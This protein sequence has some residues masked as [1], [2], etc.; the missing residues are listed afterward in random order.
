MKG[1]QG[2]STR[3]LGI[4]LIGLGIISQRHELGFQ[5]A[6]AKAKV[7]AL[8]D[9]N[10][11][12]A[13][14]RA[15]PYKANAYSD[16]HELIAD[17]NIDIVDIALPHNL[18]FPVAKAAIQAGKHVLVEKPLALTSAEAEE[19]CNCADA[20]GVKLG[21]AE[22]TRFV[23]AYVAAE[24]VLRDGVLGE[25]RLVRT[26]L[27]GSEINRL[28][29]TSNWKGR[30]DGSGGGVIID[31]APHSF[32]LLKWLIGG[33][34]D[35]FTFSEQL[36]PEAEVEDN[37]VIVG[38]FDNG[39]IFSAEFSFT[40]E[41]PWNEH[42]EIHGSKGS[43]IVDQLLNPPVRLIMGG[44]DYSGTALSNV[45]YDPVGWKRYSVMTGVAD[46]IRAVA[47]GQP[48]TVSG[49]DGLYVMRVIEKA[50]ESA[51]KGIPIT[52]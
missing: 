27:S 28:T 16:Y 31:A 48:P 14:E 40:T 9:I 8:C 3:K 43:L 13:K 25:V 47:A 32:Y 11:D 12:L 19:L 2:M 51:S 5:Q 17:P 42:L 26:F 22:N 7:V 38:H 21:L 10:L 39:A 30:R 4:G 6:N 20:K 45:P 1:Y 44:G 49:R 15:L 37:A 46:F 34:R 50:Y 33:I 41:V 36:V 52:L 24:K 18:H 29:V 23:R 35:V